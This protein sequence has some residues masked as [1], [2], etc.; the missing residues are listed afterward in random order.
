MV[1]AWP[2][3]ITSTSRPRVRARAIAAATELTESAITA[4]SG[5]AG[6]KRL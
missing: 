4:S 3:L 5:C 1:D 6:A 2:V